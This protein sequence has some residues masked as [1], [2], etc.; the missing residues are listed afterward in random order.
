MDSSSIYQ[1]NTDE[2]MSLFIDSENYNCHHTAK[3]LNVNQLGHLLSATPTSCG[4]STVTFTA[5]SHFIRLPKGHDDGPQVFCWGCRC[6]RQPQCINKSTVATEW[7]IARRPL[8]TRHHRSFSCYSTTTNY[9][10]LCCIVHINGKHCW[11]RACTT[12]TLELAPNQF[13]YCHRL[14]ITFLGQTPCTAR[15]LG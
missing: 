15:G 1:R 6:R 2:I 13:L 14:S 4:A 10:S 7:K 9:W 12:P 11:R 3:K 5:S 8:F